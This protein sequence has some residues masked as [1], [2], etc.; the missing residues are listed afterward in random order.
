MYAADPRFFA[1]GTKSGC[2]QIF[3]EE[4]VPHPM[5]FENLYSADEIVAAIAGMRARKPAM[6]KVI[7]KLNE[8]VS[9]VGNAVVDLEGLP[10]PGRPG[11]AA[12]VGAAAAQHALRA[13]GHRLRVVRREGRR[14]RRRSSKS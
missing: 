10:P 6:R 8:G 4:G 2:R 11:R 1:F 5:G 12:A 3:A 14:A 13:G 7:A 9:G